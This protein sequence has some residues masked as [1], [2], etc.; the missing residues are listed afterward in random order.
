MIEEPFPVAQLPIRYGVSRPAIYQHLK[1]LKI[2]TTRYEGKAC[3]S[4]DDLERLDALDKFRKENPDL[5]LARFIESTPAEVYDSL[6][7]PPD[8]L[9][10]LDDRDITADVTRL[11]QLIAGIAELVRPQP[12]PL[13]HYVWLERAVA[14]SWIL[15][16][17]EV[18]QLIGSRPT[19]DHK[20][21]GCFEFVKAGKKIG[22]EHGWRVYKVI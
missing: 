16:T 17:N 4:P 3:I 5:S 19:G 15:T 21:W 18:K 6:D 10:T 12:E 22:R 20:S 14:G 9:D 2:E 8:M 11:T 7:N 1:F 13:Q